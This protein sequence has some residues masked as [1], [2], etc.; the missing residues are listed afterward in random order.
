MRAS[1]GG[2]LD[3]GLRR[4]LVGYGCHVDYADI[5]VWLR[6]GVQQSWEKQLDEECVAE[7]G[8]CQLILDIMVILSS[9]TYMVRR[10]LDLIAFLRDTGRYSHDTRVA[11]QDIEAI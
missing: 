8:G 9:G 2:E 5:G 4:L 6:G 7:L 10:E 1:K 3:A 11:I